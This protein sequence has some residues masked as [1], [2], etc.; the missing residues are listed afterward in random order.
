MDCNMDPTHHEKI[1]DKLMQYRGKIPK[2]GQVFDK[3]TQLRCRL[4]RENIDRIISSIDALAE[5][6]E[7]GLI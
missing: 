2:D 1:V 7:L 4:M 6:F 5:K 3:D